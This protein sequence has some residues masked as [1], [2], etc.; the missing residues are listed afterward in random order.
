[1]KCSDVRELLDDFVD[2]ELGHDKAS[3]VAEHIAKCPDCSNRLTAL[4]EMLQEASALPR[5]IAPKHDLWPRIERSISHKKVVAFPSY[6]RHVWKVAAAAAVFIAAITGAYFIGL[7]QQAPAIVQVETSENLMH[8]SN[9]PWS[10]VPPSL[11]Q[12]RVQLRAALEARK[13]SLSP[14]TIVMV[15]E[16]L[17]IID[18][19]ITEISLALNEAPNNPRLQRQLYF[20][21]S[22][23]INLLQRAAS[24]PAEI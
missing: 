21:C 12:T 9:K 16:N 14:Q 1:M 22:Q 11:Q 18:R 10:L 7:H 5:E 24:F 15:E 19:A 17:E 13:D 3:A 6:S 23:E 8:V 20:A 2:Q 4:H